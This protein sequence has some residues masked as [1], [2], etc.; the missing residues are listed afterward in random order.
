[1]KLVSDKWLDEDRTRLFKMWGCSDSE[2]AEVLAQRP[3]T[4]PYYEVNEVN[5]ELV[6]TLI[7]PRV[8]GG[9]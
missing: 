6:K 7:D 9:K 5:G 4:R 2:I 3:K 1:M 8:K